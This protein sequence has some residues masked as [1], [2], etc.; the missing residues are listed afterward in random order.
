[1]DRHQR[2]LEP[3]E[4]S[5]RESD[6]ASQR[7][8]D[9]I[10]QIADLCDCLVEHFHRHRSMRVE[11][12]AICLK[13]VDAAEASSCSSEDVPGNVTEVASHPHDRGRNMLR[14]HAGVNA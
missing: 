13:V 2:R 6:D 11:L 9:N 10:A 5:R 8:R 12:H 14:C 3:I 1:M 7:S 4:A